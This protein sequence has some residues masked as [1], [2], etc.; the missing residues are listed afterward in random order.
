[1]ILSKEELEIIGSALG[2]RESRMLADAELYKKQGNREAQMDCI[3]EWR[4][5]NKLHERVDALARFLK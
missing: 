5:A 2:E 4:K 1:M 3:N